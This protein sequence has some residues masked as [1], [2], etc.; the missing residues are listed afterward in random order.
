MIVFPLGVLLHKVKCVSTR[1]ACGE[2]A[3]GCQAKELCKYLSARFDFISVVR[4]HQILAFDLIP[5][6]HFT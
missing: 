1:Q 5:R 2:A 6:F 3:T 4:V